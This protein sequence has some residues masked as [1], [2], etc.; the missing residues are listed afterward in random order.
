MALKLR[1]KENPIRLKAVGSP[2]R[3]SV[4]D[5]EPIFLRPRTG[6]LR[7]KVT[8]NTIRVSVEKGV[9]IYPSPYTGDYEVTPSTET[10]TLLTKGKA[11][12]EH[13]TVHPIPSNYGL[14]TWN[15]ST[16]T[17]S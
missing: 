16:L 14:I 8:S 2:F 1:V 6:R 13:I 9:L 12:S 11:L 3:L 5:R 17:V 10:Q 7:L 4:T 15:G